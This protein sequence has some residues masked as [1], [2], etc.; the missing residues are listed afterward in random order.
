MEVE[1]GIAYDTEKTFAQARWIATE[2]DR[3][4]LYVKIPA[5]M[6]GLP[7]I[8]LPSGLSDAGLP[9]AIQL[10]GAWGQDAALLDVASWCEAELGPMPAP[11]V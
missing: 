4:N 7:A 3:P 10:V 5:T 6:A 8:S 1:P 9:L 11:P 2:V